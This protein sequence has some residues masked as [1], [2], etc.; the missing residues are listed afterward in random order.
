LEYFSDKSELLAHLRSIKEYAFDGRA[1]IRSLYTVE[2]ISSAYARMISEMFLS[3]EA[4]Y[5]IENA[6][7]KE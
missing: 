4:D 7:T 5:S 3:I 1:E 2:G 6:A